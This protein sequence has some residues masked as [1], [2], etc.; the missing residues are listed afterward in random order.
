MFYR[1]IYQFIDPLTGKQKL[2]NDNNIL[3]FLNNIYFKNYAKDLAVPPFKIYRNVSFIRGVYTANRQYRY[4]LAAE[5]CQMMTSNEYS[6]LLAQAAQWLQNEL[7]IQKQYQ[8]VVYRY[9]KLAEKGQA[10]DLELETELRQRFGAEY[11]PI[12]IKRLSRNNELGNYYPVQIDRWVSHYNS[13]RYLFNH[14]RHTSRGNWGCGRVNHAKSACAR[15]NYQ[16]KIIRRKYRNSEIGRKLRHQNRTYRK[17]HPAD[18]PVFDDDE[19]R[20]SR[21]STGWKHS[22]HAPKSYLQHNKQKHFSHKYDDLK[23][24]VAQQIND[25]IN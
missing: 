15:S 18:F 14:K 8:A 22:S 3:A 9:N 5:N 10:N 2:L 13:W 1:K 21:F 4:Y 19:Y 23:R 24:R 11:N 20:R 12:N 25:T 16:L 7:E 17:H 6:K